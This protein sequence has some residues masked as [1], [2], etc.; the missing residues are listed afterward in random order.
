MVVDALSKLLMGSVPHIKEEKRK[1]AKYVHRLT[2]LAIIFMEST[3]GGIYVTNRVES[4]L[5]PEVK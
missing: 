3:E 2:C 5:V 4:S 1:L